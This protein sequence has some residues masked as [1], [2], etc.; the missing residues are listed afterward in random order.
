MNHS[1]PIS[2]TDFINFIVQLNQ[3]LAIYTI[4]I[5]LFDIAMDAETLTWL[6]FAGGITLMILET[7]L[8]GGVALFLGISGVGVGILRFLGFLSDPV[9]ATAVWL[10]SSIGLTIAIRPIIKKYFKPE[11]LIISRIESFYIFFKIVNCF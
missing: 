6:F 3:K 2:R 8:P 9:S 4:N 10:L 5:N 11:K 1:I 7:I